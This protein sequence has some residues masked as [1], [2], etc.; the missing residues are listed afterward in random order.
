[1]R[2]IHVLPACGLAAIDGALLIGAAFPAFRRYRRPTS[3]EGEGV[4]LT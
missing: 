2:G 1:V 3:Q 4:A